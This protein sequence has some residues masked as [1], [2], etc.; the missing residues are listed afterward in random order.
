M[1]N[2]KGK[3]LKALQENKKALIE[4][5]PNIYRDGRINFTMLKKLIG[6]QIEDEEEHYEFTWPGKMRAFQQAYTQSQYTLHPEQHKS[7]QWDSTNH[8]YIEGDNLE[9]LRILQ[10]SYS[11]QVKMI[12]I[13]PPYNTGNDFTYQDNFY[14]IKIEENDELTSKKSSQMMRGRHHSNWLNM[15]YPRLILAR[16]LLRDDGMIFISID[17]REL[18]NL[19][20]IC[21]EVF[22]VENFIELFVWTKTNTPPSLSYKSRKTVEYILC[23]EKKRDNQKYKGEPLEYGDAP[24]LNTGNPVK[25]LSFPQGTIRFHIPDGTYKAGIHGRLEL[26]N[27]LSIK[28][29]LNQNEIQCLGEFKWSQKTVNEEIEKGTYFLIKTKRFSIR[30]QRKVNPNHF[31]APTNF[32][33]QKQKMNHT[34]HYYSIGTNETATKELKKLGLGGYFDYP[35]PVNLIKYLIQATTEKNDIIMD[36]FA[37]SST[38]AQAVLELN[39]EKDE[40][41]KFIMVQIPERLSKRTKAYQ[42]GFHNLCDIGQERIRR[43]GKKINKTDKEIDVGFKVFKLAEPIIKAW[44][45]KANEFHRNEKENVLYEIFL[46]TGIPLHIPWEKHTFQQKIIYYLPSEKAM[47]CLSCHLTKNFFQALLKEKFKLRKVI[48]F[49]NAFTCKNTYKEVEQL[50]KIV[51]I[52]WKLI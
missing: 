40:K 41:R 31:K 2:I 39:T 17:E 3:S 16:K 6:E 43:V 28:D 11:Q 20:K 29:G 13:D 5:F 37:G 8:L 24:L 52:Q 46:K 23:Y 10:K 1:D 47:I 32:I 22:G 48:G 38:T 9:V 49:K 50:L 12:Y 18:A 14:E 25:K 36:F 34:D 26:L 19:K 45:M 42:K 30:F 33:H 7:V 27:D 21:D 4:L 44:N 51:N 15:M 35:K